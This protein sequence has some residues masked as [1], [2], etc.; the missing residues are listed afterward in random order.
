[1][2]TLWSPLETRESSRACDRLSYQVDGRYVKDAR[3]VGETIR[4]CCFNTC[5]VT[6][7]QIAFSPTRC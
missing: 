7:I 3:G 5:I 4:R 6:I 1:M 2:P